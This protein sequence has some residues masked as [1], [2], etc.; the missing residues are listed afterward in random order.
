MATAHRSFVVGCGDSGAC[1]EPEKEGFGT[2]VHDEPLEEL[3][4]T[5]YYS[6]SPLC[7]MRRRH[8]A[9]YLSLFLYLSSSLVLSLSP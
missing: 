5:H 9:P 4:A 2:P 8:E 1:Q 6:T 7:S 3:R